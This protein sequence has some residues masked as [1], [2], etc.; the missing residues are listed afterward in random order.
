[1]SFSSKATLALLM[2]DP[3]PRSYGVLMASSDEYATKLSVQVGID[4]GDGTWTWND[5]TDDVRA[6]DWDRGAVDN[7]VQPVVGTANVTLA[8][9][10]GH[11]SP[12]NTT[13]G[14]FAGTSESKILPNTPMRIGATRWNPLDH[15]E[16][17]WMPLFSGRIEKIDEE[18][19]ENVDSYV[20]YGLVDVSASLAAHGNGKF[21]GGGPGALNAWVEGG[22][23]ALPLVV[24]LAIN[25]QF[26]IDAVEYTMTPGT[27]ST[28]ASLAT[29]IGAAVKTGPT[30]FS[31]IVTP[32]ATSIGILLTVVATGASSLV[33]HH[34][35]NDVLN[36]LGFID[37]D[38]FETYFDPYYGEVGADMLP[39]LL[40]DCDFGFGYIDN[41]VDIDP[42][43]PFWTA[44]PLAS[45]ERSAN[46]LVAA[47]D[48]GTACNVMVYGSSSGCIIAQRFGPA[49]DGSPDFGTF[50]NDMT[51]D[52]D[53]IY[54]IVDIVSY[55]ST[56][57][58]LNKVTGQRVQPTSV[59]LEVLNKDQRMGATHGGT[60]VYSQSTTADRSASTIHNADDSP[61]ELSGTHS[62]IRHHAEFQ[63]FATYS[64]NHRFTLEDTNGFQH[65][66]DTAGGHSVNVQGMISFLATG[67]SIFITTSSSGDIKL[68]SSGPGN[69]Y[70]E[71]EKVDPSIGNTDG[72]V[73]KRVGGVW[74][75]ASTAGLDSTAMHSG[76]AAG[77]DLAG[78][79]PNPTIGTDKVVTAK[80]ANSNVTLAK[81][82]NIA[83]QAILGNNTGG[84]A[85]PLALTAAQVR[86]LL[87]LVVGTDVQAQDAELAALAALV[88]AADKLPYFTGSGTAALAAF[89]AAGRALVDD[90]DAAAQRTTLGLGTAA[91]HATGD[92]DAS[93]AAAAAQAA[94]QPL[95]SD[96]TT[97]AGLTATTDNMIQSVGSAWASRTP[98]QV[99]AALAIGESDVASLT[100]DLAAKAPLASPT[101]TGHPVGVTESSSDN[102]TRLATTAY[103]TTAVAAI[104][105]SLDPFVQKMVFY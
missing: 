77:G 40:A 63:R 104:P 46:R 24:Q 83:D 15:S 47:Q 90:A 2:A 35:T 13:V 12:W 31:V 75:G 89:T 38:T 94:S 1:M 96:L 74:E 36:G 52:D 62:S 51:L 49:V 91:T 87:S 10:N 101:F 34:G 7:L 56:D 16:I 78:T 82:A 59:E 84:A 39:A 43:D 8:N 33:L 102:S 73:L 14:P 27:Y 76:D 64:D 4:N 32:T 53:P 19:V 25:D 17:I 41:V 55:A 20:T 71:G 95:D 26:K 29:A 42:L 60:T 18:Q 68:L 50:T 30:A 65:V 44:T 3:T 61:D 66:G 58:I 86:T 48:I 11:Y 21:M 6:V 57:R 67:A 99:K 85:A 100:T 93:G 22:A 103:V 54:P 72:N 9:R 70:L 37:G 97:I 28:L 80:I 105:A 98:T 5:V 92:Y 23:V 88:S 45:P 69:V 79:Y 81:L